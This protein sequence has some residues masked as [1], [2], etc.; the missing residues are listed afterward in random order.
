MSSFVPS[1]HL[2]AELAAAVRVRAYVLPATK[3]TRC[4]FLTLC[5]CV[6]CMCSAW[7]PRTQTSA[8][9]KSMLNGGQVVALVSIHDMQVQGPENI[10]GFTFISLRPGGGVLDN[11][12][13]LHAGP[14]HSASSRGEGSPPFDPR[15]RQP[16]T[17]HMGA[18]SSINVRTSYE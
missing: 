1:M 4:A 2:Q 9:V 18:L 6:V 5:L 8:G 11:W 12:H 15:Q 17:G 3:C 14:A 10:I 13:P 7:R 16:L